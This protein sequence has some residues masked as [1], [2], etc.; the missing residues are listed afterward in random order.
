M[1]PLSRPHESREHLRSVRIDKVLTGRYTAI[2][3]FVGI[4]GLVF[5]L[6]FGVIGKLLSDAAGAWA[7]ARLGGVVDQCAHRVGTQSLCACA[8]SSWT[9][10]WAA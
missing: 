4:M 1:R 10:Y 8:R 5:C 2:P 3:C 9:V 7:S 6:T